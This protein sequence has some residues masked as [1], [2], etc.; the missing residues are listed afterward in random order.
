MQSAQYWAKQND[1]IIASKLGER[2]VEDYCHWATRELSKVSDSQLNAVAKDVMQ[3]HFLHPSDAMYPPDLREIMIDVFSQKGPKPTSCAR[4]SLKSSPTRFSDDPDKTLE[5][6]L[7]YRILSRERLDATMYD[8]WKRRLKALE[9]ISKGYDRRLELAKRENSEDAEHMFEEKLK[10]EEAVFGRH[11]EKWKRS[12]ADF[13]ILYRK[14][15]SYKNVTADNFQPNSQSVD[16]NEASKHDDNELAQI[17]AKKG[18]RNHMEDALLKVLPDKA[19]VG[20]VL[21]AAEAEARLPSTYTWTGQSAIGTSAQTAKRAIRDAAQGKYAGAAEELTKACPPLLTEALIDLPAR[22]IKLPNL[23]GITASECFATLAIVRSKLKLQPGSSIDELAFESAQHATQTEAGSSITRSAARTYLRQVGAEPILDE[24]DSEI[25]IIMPLSETFFRKWG[26]VFE[27]LPK[28][29]D[30]WE[31][32]GEVSTLI[33]TTRPH[34]EQIE[35]LVKSLQQ[36]VPGYFDLR[37]PR[38]LSIAE[39]QAGTSA[40]RELIGDNE[41]VILWMMVPGQQHGLVFAVS[42]QRAAWATMTL[43]GDEINHRVIRLRGQIDPCAYGSKQGNCSHTGLAFD[44]QDAYELYQS[45]LGQADIQNVIGTASTLLIVPSGV[46]T[47]LPPS[48]L[49]ASPPHKNSQYDKSSDGWLGADWLIKKKA[50]AILPSVSSLR[51]LRSSH[52]TT[53]ADIPQSPNE[54]LFMFACVFRGK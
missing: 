37:S 13:A 15:N 40:P 21:K 31:M 1:E 14:R 5:E 34:N 47:T 46:L 36:T 54:R 43:T 19:A 11:S 29:K 38:P 17:D 49:I 20:E 30:P 8:E 41:A 28:L 2:I 23:Q 18:H 3:C 7:E 6:R 42:K 35:T 52:K 45:L 22:S 16:A 44:R 4:K 9:T 50:I 26:P 32:I 10:Y 24:I 25:N 33:N 12:S 53:D 48:V 51:T 39:L 27:D